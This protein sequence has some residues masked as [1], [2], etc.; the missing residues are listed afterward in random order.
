MTNTKIH[1]PFGVT[2]QLVVVLACFF[3]LGACGEKKPAVP[4]SETAPALLRAKSNAGAK[5]F[6]IEP[7]NG[8]TV[9]SPVTL[10]FGVEGIAL[11]KA[12][13]VL[14]N[15]GHHHILIDTSELPPMDQPLPF[16]DLLIHFGQAQ[17]ESSVN[18]GPGSHT[19]QLIF[20]GGN[21][22]PHDPPVVS[23]RI[24]VTVR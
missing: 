14:D 16:S 3:F 17:T 1:G 2:K 8:A 11:E 20:A 7:Q 19:L 15:S 23:E 9:T 22:I 21:H 10:K 24:T 18:L 4:A 5:I 12:G 6:I 13:P